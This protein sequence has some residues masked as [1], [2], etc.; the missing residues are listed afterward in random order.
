VITVADRGPGSALTWPKSI[1]VA[2]V[3]AVILSLSA[4][5]IAAP[6][7]T[8][9]PADPRYSPP[10]S[11]RI[12]TYNGSLQTFKNKVA[13]YERRKVANEQRR[14]EL[15]RIARS[16]PGRVAPS[17]EFAREFN[18]KI[19]A[20]NTEMEALS[21]EADAL[22]AEEAQLESDRAGIAAAARLE[23]NAIVKASPPPHTAAQP[24]QQYQRIP[25]QEQPVQPQ[26]RSG[27]N[28]VHP[29]KPSKP[30][31]PE[32]RPTTVTGPNGEFLPG[33]PPGVKGTLT[34]T[35]NGYTYALPPTEGI[36]PRVA[37]IRVMGP[38]T[39]SE[40]H[41]YPNG[42]V[43]YMNNEPIPQAVNPLTGRTVDPSDPYRHIRL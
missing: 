7:P 20:A 18:Q 35:G 17:P 42:Y 15:D 29:T 14:S 32:V 1:A 2:V 24:G 41:E 3:W 30:P 39:T 6:D 28:P 12:A 27:G 10:V 37:Y 5:G 4:V 25:R 19:R 31:P 34:R 13:D 36:D 23:L 38:T 22:N 8:P 21:G 43:V 16:Y 9:F 40:G 26:A 33:V 11:S